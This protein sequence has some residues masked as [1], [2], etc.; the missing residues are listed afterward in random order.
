MDLAFVLWFQSINHWFVLAVFRMFTFFAEWWI[1]LAATAIF[2]IWG[3]W[4]K[5]LKYLI[6]LGIAHLFVFAIKELVA[7]PRPFTHNGVVDYNHTFGYSFPSGHTLNAGIPAFFYIHNFKKKLFIIIPLLVYVGM[8]A[9][10]RIYLGQHFASDVVFSILFSWLAIWA[11]GRLYDYVEARILRRNK[12]LT[13][14]SEEQTQKI[15]RRFAH[16]LND[17]DI[18]TLKGD[19][20]AGKT[21]F[22]RGIA[23]PATSPTFTLENQYATRFGR[24]KHYDLYRIENKSELLEFY[25][26]EGITFVE[27]PEKAEI[28]GTVSVEIEKVNDN[29]RKI[30]INY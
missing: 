2:F 20:G 30:H 18:V 3:G 12:T 6:I 10:S 23:T 7:R 14:N 19:L 26:P 13:S 27:W 15:A 9:L 22:V 11:F 5:A 8:V 29:E 25:N 21:A 28:K 17:G 16:T 1:I 24:I 4:R